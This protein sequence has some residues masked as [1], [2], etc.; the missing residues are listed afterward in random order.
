MCS[1]KLKIKV[2]L[3]GNIIAASPMNFSSDAV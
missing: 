1:M 3:L 2:K